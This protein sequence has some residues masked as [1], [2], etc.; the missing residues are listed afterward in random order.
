M[1]F[2]FFFIH[3]FAILACITTI[4]RCQNDD[5]SH[6]AYWYNKIVDVMIFHITG[7]KTARPVEVPGY[8]RYV[9]DEKIHYLEDLRN[10][11]RYAVRNAYNLNDA[12]DD[13]KTRFK[14]ASMDQR[15]QIA[16]DWLYRELVGSS[17]M[18]IEERRLNRG[19]EIDYDK[20]YQ[21]ELRDY[22]Q[23]F[24][25]PF[26]NTL[27]SASTNLRLAR[28]YYYRMRNQKGLERFNADPINFSLSRE[29]VIQTVSDIYLAATSP[30]IS[31]KKTHAMRD[32]RVVHAGFEYFDNC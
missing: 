17:S 12:T 6:N 3:I 10:F 5:G 13:E 31:D 11:C 24:S 4:A 25:N 8:G 29:Q 9:P 26:L 19:I 7:V 18:M 30:E 28:T 16:S 23:R 1:K 21:R 15:I 20:L 22:N 2:I 32:L 14:G 27:V